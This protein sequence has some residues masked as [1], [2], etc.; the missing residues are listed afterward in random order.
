MLNKYEL[1]VLNLELARMLIPS[2]IALT[3]HVAGK[4]PFTS[5]MFGLLMDNVAVKNKKEITEVS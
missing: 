3:S 2:S 1:L 4:N 5:L